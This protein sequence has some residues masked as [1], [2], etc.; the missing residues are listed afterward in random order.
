[1]HSKELLQAAETKTF[2]VSMAY[3][4]SKKLRYKASRS[5]SPRRI[6]YTMRGL[7]DADNAVGEIF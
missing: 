7:N 6:Q 3:F 1:M 4:V 2:N 5:E